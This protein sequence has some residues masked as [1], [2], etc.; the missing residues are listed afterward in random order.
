MRILLAGSCSK[1]KRGDPIDD[2]KKNS[3]ELFG[4]LGAGSCRREGC[5][6]VEEQ[7]TVRERCEG[8][9]GGSESFLGGASEGFI[10]AAGG[11][12]AVQKGKLVGFVDIGGGLKA[13]IA[14]Q[15][16]TGKGFFQV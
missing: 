4:E 5:V 12:G 6:S 10:G 13:S 7:Q 1:G 11:G 15:S 16:L 2:G 14:K 9:R 8:L 3:G